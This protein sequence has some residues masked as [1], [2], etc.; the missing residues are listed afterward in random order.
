[1]KTAYLDNN[2]TTPMYDTVRDA[3]LTAMT[4]VGNPSSVHGAGRTARAMMEKARDSVA[5]LVNGPNDGVIFTSG[6]TEANALAVLGSARQRI[7][8][9]AV[10]HPAV[11]NARADVQIIPVIQ[12]IAEIA[13]LAHEH[14]AWLHCDAVQA[15]GKIPFDMTALGCDLVT[16]SAHKIGGPHGVGALIKRDKL[17]LQAVQ[18]GG[19]QERSFRGGTENLAGIVG[20]G[21]AAREELDTFR[22][23]AMRDAL[24][25]KIKEKGAVIFAEDVD[26]LPNTICF[27]LKGLSSERQVMAL[28]LAGVMVSAGSAC[29]SGKVKAS[30]V[31]EAMGVPEDLGGCAIRVSLGWQNTISDIEDFML[32]WF[33]LAD[34][35]LEKQRSGQTAA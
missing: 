34:R 12:P 21:A 4:H 14:G 35:V 15:V 17:P 2:A 29:S 3:M 16:V 13:A 25:L 6:G 27:A 32:A 5:A 10:E 24:G 28:D 22:L 18:K 33:A 11:L 20:F 23:K 26:R 8:V 1:M 19:G 30:H 9:S 31:L 7:L